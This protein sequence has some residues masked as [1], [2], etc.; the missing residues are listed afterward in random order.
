[1]DPGSRD[2]FKWP[3][4]V[5]IKAVYYAH[6]NKCVV[7]ADV[8]I[9]RIR[10][11]GAYSDNSELVFSLDW[12]P[13]RRV[14]GGGNWKFGRAFAVTGKQLLLEQRLIRKAYWAY[15]EGV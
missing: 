7:H 6:V 11:E 5:E 1:M 10:R 13:S 3:N 15:W 9:F 2:L 4:I 8:D 12:R 14:G